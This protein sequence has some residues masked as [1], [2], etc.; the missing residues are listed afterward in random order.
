MYGRRTVSSLSRLLVV[1][2]L[3]LPSAS[4]A[5]VLNPAAVRAACGKDLTYTD[6]IPQAA[7]D[8]A[9]MNGRHVPCTP[10][11][12]RRAASPHRSCG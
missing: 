7:A 6:H 8:G 4:G 5:V 11:T 1:A 12:G 9:K 3:L 10:T 2:V